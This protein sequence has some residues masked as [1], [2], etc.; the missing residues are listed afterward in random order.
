MFWPVLTASKVTVGVIT[1]PQQR[2]RE[3]F[4]DTPVGELGYK[5]AISPMARP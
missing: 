5:G 4:P 1:T 3:L 2:V